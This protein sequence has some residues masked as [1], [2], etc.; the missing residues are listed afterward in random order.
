MEEVRKSKPNQFQNL[1]FISLC[2]L[3]IMF[4][5]GDSLYKTSIQ[6]QLPKEEVNR[7]ADDINEDT[8]IDS[9][10]QGTEFMN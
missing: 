7:P 10:W 3:L 9:I 6:S 8:R 1:I 4:F 2:W 5:V